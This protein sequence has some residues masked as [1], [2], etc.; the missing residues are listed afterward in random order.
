MKNNVAAENGKVGAI[1]FSGMQQRETLT[2]GGCY[3]P[4]S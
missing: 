1:S 3:S 2:I 4:A